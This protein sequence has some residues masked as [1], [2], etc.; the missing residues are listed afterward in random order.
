MSI[1]IEWSINH[2]Q[3]RKI[4]EEN[5]MFLY[6]MRKVISEDPKM[7]AT[8][9]P[10]P[11]FMA[12]KVPLR[13]LIYWWEKSDL[14][15]TL[16]KDSN[17]L[18]LVFVGGFPLS[19]SIVSAHYVDLSGN[20]RNAKELCSTSL[21]EILGDF[22]KCQPENSEYHPLKTKPHFK[23]NH[24]I[25]FPEID[26][27]KNDFQ[28]ETTAYEL[29]E[30]LNILKQKIQNDLGTKIATEVQ[31]NMDA[32]H[33]QNRIRFAAIEKMTQSL[34]NR[35]KTVEKQVALPILL[36]KKEAFT[37]LLEIYFKEFSKIKSDYCYVRSR[38]VRN[39]KIKLQQKEIKDC[40]YKSAK[41]E[42]DKEYPKPEEWK[43]GQIEKIS[44]KIFNA[45]D[46]SYLKSI[47]MI[48]PFFDADSFEIAKKIWLCYTLV[49]F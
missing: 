7:S 16:D 8:L 29:E 15:T 42:L 24:T 13:K 30:L 41:E 25:S 11:H 22:N 28:E 32:L 49:L 46:L 23:N 36:N 20:V 35:I 27:N 18:L 5:A 19:G 47:N 43:K 39:L 26:T 2:Q 17:F 9:V 6:S 14:A 37:K 21:G 38:K 48:R 45:Q 40:E 3:F 33:I 1:Q 34:L 12:S 44:T 31:Q 10:H 4:F